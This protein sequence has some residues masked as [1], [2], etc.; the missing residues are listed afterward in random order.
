MNPKMGEIN[1][2]SGCDEEQDS[3]FSLPIMNSI[4]LQIKALKKSQ[5]LLREQIQDR[6]NE[7]FAIKTLKSVSEHQCI[8]GRMSMALKLI[9]QLKNAQVTAKSNQSAVAQAQKDA[10]KQLTAVSKYEV[11]ALTVDPLSLS[12]MATAN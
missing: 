7:L 6:T 4:Q 3:G 8:K 5:Q 10:L 2:D 12:A 11:R 1:T 9:S